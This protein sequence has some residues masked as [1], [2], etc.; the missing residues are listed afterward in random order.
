MG[1]KVPPA[2][3]EGAALVVG[4]EMEVSEGTGA[5]VTLALPVPTALPVAPTTPSVVGVATPTDFDT[6]ESDT[7]RRRG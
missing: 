1:E 7:W 3:R 5:C 4:V 6:R 2:V